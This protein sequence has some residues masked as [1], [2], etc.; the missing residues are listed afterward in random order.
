MQG[1]TDGRGSEL[2]E[3]ARRY[4]ECG[5]VFVSISISN[6]LSLPNGGIPQHKF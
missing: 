5:A 2:T 3:G 6:S 1:N 4:N